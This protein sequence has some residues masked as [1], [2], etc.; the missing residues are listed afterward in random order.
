VAKPSPTRTPNSATAMKPVPVVNAVLRSQEKIAPLKT[1]T[2]RRP[3][4]N[5]DEDY[6]APDT[7]VYYGKKR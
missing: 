4:H 2:V 5:E 7:Y 6:V 3:H 1:K